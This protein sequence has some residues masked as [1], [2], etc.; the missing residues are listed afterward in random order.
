M[1]FMGMQFTW[2]IRFKCTCSQSVIW[3]HQQHINPIQIRVYEPAVP[4]AIPFA[5]AHETKMQTVWKHRVSIVSILHTFF[6]YM[7]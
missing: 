1:C 3:H 7:I 2:S 5:A 4:A 6:E